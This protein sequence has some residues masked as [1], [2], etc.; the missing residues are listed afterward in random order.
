[1]KRIFSIAFA[2]ALAGTILSGCDRDADG[3][4][5]VGTGGTVSTPAGK[6]GGSASGTVNPEKGT[7][8]GSA[9]GATSDG[10]SGSA[11]GA[12]ASK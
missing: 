7:A 5:S 6:A 4:R 8:S 2:F 1:M 11:S 3:N 12:A 10:K 9:S